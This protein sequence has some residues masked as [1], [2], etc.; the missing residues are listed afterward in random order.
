MIAGSLDYR[1]S[2]LIDY[3]FQ[4]EMDLRANLPYELFVVDRVPVVKAGPV[5]GLALVCKRVEWS[6]SLT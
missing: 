3:V 1:I 4:D 5:N 6:N 2:I